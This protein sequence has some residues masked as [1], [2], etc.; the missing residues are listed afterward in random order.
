MAKD[1]LRMSNKRFI[2]IL[3]PIIV[4]LLALLIGVT[5]AMNFFAPTMDTF[6]GKGARH[7]INPE[8]TEKW[9]TNFYEQKY[10]TSAEARA[11]GAELTKA[12]CDE[13]EVL[14][15]NDGLLPLARTQSVSPFGY[16]YLNP[17]Y[18][19]TGSGNVDASKDYVVTAEEGLAMAFDNVN[20][21]TAN[22]MRTAEPNVT[23]PTEGTSIDGNIFAGASVDLKEYDVDIYSGT[24]ES[25]S[26]TV[27]IV[28]IGRVGG[29][30]SDLTVLPYKDGT[31]HELA[32][33]EDEKATIEFAKQHCNGGVVV[34]VET[35][36]V[37]ELGELEDDDEINAIL[38][39]G[40]P[41][42]M[43]YQSIGE[44]LNGTVNPS[45]KLVDTYAA[46]LTKDP[47]FVNF[48]NDDG[49]M[50]YTNSSYHTEMWLAR[51]RGRYKFDPQV[52]FREYEEGVYLGYKFYE[53]AAHYNYYKSENMPDD[54]TDTFYNRTNGVVYPFGYGL[55]Y[56]NF[57][58]EIVSLE[59]DGNYLKLT[60][61]IENKGGVRG[62][63]VVQVYYNPPYTDFDETYK[64]EKPTANLV[65]FVKTDFIEPKTSIEIPIIFM[66]E[67]MAS[68]CFTRDNG[69][70]TTGCYVLEEGDYAITIGQ[71]SHVA[72]DTESINIPSTIWYD[73]NN[74]R[75]S[76]K[77][78]QSAWNAN[79]ESLGYPEKEPNGSYQAAT[80]RFEN[81]NEYM[82][83]RSIGKATIL[84]RTNWLGTMPTAPKDE[85]R[86]AS[87]KVIEWNKWNY[88]PFNYETD[89]I[90]GNVE[91]SKIYIPES[92]KP[93]SKQ[94]NGLLM[95]DLR[96]L[97]FYDENWDLLLDQ[98]DYT[99]SDELKYG[100]FVCAFVTGEINSV[101][102]PSTREHDGP[103]GI[104]QNSNDGTSWVPDVCAYCSEVIVAQ[105][106]NT[107]LAY[108]FG[109]SIGQESLLIDNNGW[110]APGANIHRSPF[111]GRN[112]E[113]YSEDAFI[114]GKMAA[115][116]I[117][118]AGDMGVYCA[119]KHF[120]FTDQENQRW[121][122]PCIWATEQTIRETYL[123]A[124][125]IGIKEAR[126]TIKYI[127]DEKGTVAT[128][129]MKAADCLMMAGWASPGSK[130]CATDYD[131]LYEVT[132]GEW[133]F[134]GFMITD[135]DMGFKAN[136]DATVN[137]LVRAGCDMH[138]LDMTMGPG[139]YTDINSATGM[140][141]LRKSIKN[142]LYTM[143]NSNVTQG[144]APGAIIYYD[145]SPWAIGL[146]IGDIV[147]GLLIVGGI[148]W[149]VLRLLDEKKHPEKYKRKEKI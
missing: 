57:N 23:E 20:E 107:D 45:G 139:T 11:A 145:M 24:E 73:N 6:L 85:D 131:L 147:V 91:G 37:M 67:D 102:K 33:T 123:K 3:A 68:Y 15:K 60:V 104:S 7:V 59:D 148:V 74:P 51:F 99:A 114:S 50:N 149:I 119:F 82:T 78:A 88:E 55:S 128:K 126:K 63:D 87:E 143:A 96:G 25:C 40:G 9:D 16:C 98:I 69:D 32:L 21:K 64:I 106:W 134:Q 29:E 44:I 8:G 35:S 105:T 138:M 118:G 31:K 109:Y 54:I 100:L 83:D 62:K 13:G 41:G 101:G 86:V 110:Y 46:D 22:V 133:G 34:I 94:D 49:T 146:M 90:L 113:Y 26:D 140:T 72:Y 127:A 97:S 120:A 43:G 75:E 130:W 129:T 144:A 53:T 28:F 92:E 2:A 18:G 111:G 1:K 80:N 76:E 89:K 70:G 47:T 12:L 66:K 38:L 84:S 14:L 61:R 48:D 42:S 103:Q 136:D 115:A 135:Y 132:R 95:S 30:G 124:F 121:Y 112:F 137:K 142:V 27:G 108:E 36:N 125:E 10:S 56:T 39:V 58:Q 4:V 19:G 116:T 81:C 79:G 17:L 52:P 65:A 77:L 93:L 117:S 5:V 71:D 141:A 122:N